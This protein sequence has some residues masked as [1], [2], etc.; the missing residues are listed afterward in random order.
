MK[1]LTI[2]QPYAELI[3]RGEKLVENRTWDVPLVDCVPYRGP[4][5]IHAGLSKKW[6][7]TYEPLPE[8]MDF[9]AIV[10]VVDLIYSCQVNYLRSRYC[11]DRYRHL[12]HHKHTIGT[13]C[14][15]LEN[16]R[17]FVEPISYRGRQGLFDIPNEIVQEAL[18]HVNRNG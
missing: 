12:A 6:L 3:L 2:L 4:L 5:L 14:W 17:R 18:T 11:D 16:P 7:D 10:G 15:V 8:K 9:G 13:Y 1:A